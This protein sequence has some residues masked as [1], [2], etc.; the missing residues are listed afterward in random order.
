MRTD[1]ELWSVRLCHQKAN[2]QV[3]SGDGIKPVEGMQQQNEYRSI[4]RV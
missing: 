3:T 1:H 4:Y 2:G